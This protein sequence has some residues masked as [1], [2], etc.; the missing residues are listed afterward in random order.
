MPQTYIAKDGSRHSFPDDATP[1]EIQA[2]AD[3]I[4]GSSAAPDEWQPQQWDNWRLNEISKQ[5]QRDRNPTME[6]IPWYQRAVEGASKS[7][8]D[9]GMGLGQFAGL[10]DQ[11][12]VDQH[13]RQDD[14]LMRTG[15]GAGGDVLGQIGQLAVPVTDSIK[16]FSYLGKWAPTARAAA[17]GG[18]F[19][20]AQPVETGDTR[21]GNAAAGALF[22]AGGERI[23]AGTK[24]LAAGAASRLDVPAKALAAKARSAGIPLSM[25]DLSKNPMIRTIANQMERL[26]LSGATKA[27]EKQQEAF[28]RAVARSFGLDAPRITPD[29][30]AARK[31]AVGKQ[32]ENIASRNELAVSPQMM[33]KLG[34]LRAEAQRLGGPEAAKRIEMWSQELLGK[35]G[36]SGKVPGKAYQSFDSRLGQEIRGGQGELKHYLGQLRSIAREAM[37]N[38]ISGRDRKA[39]DIARQQY[40]NIKQVEPLVAKAEGGNISA[41]LLMGRVTATNAGKAR[42]ATGQ[43][44]ELGDLAQIGQRFMKSSPNS[45]TADRAL[46]N[47]TLAS[48]L[49]GAQHYGL[50]DP[51]TA[52]GLG[53]LLMGNRAGLGVLNSKALTQGGSRTLAGLARVTKPAPKLLP[54][55]GPVIVDERY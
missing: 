40:A 50:I 30:F 17:Q 33:T 27:R 47:G 45:G 23:A 5:S 53:G 28:N 46:V 43:G 10:V 26:P 55:A 31:L 8:V 7:V 3:Q 25:S 20:A 9:T 34:A 16:A 52:L 49:F 19:S 1:E 22:G 44:G 4:D 21:L 42:M 38:S 35:V 32:I 14:A 15:W 24:A 36:A 18:I 37:D 13:A 54:A 29:L 48:G 39:W 6:G 11:E 2:A 51:A 12:T 41:P